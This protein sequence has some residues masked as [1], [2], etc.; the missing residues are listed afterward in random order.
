MPRLLISSLTP[1]QRQQLYTIANQYFPGEIRDEMLDAIDKT[2]NIPD[3][4]WRKGNFSDASR[5]TVLQVLQPVLASFP[6]RKDVLG[7]LTGQTVQEEDLTDEEL[8]N[9]L[10]AFQEYGKTPGESSVR[11]LEEKQIM[12]MAAELKGGIPPGYSIAD[13]VLRDISEYSVQN[14]RRGTYDP[15]VVENALINSGMGDSDIAIFNARSLSKGPP[16]I[17]T[18]QVESGQFQ[19]PIPGTF[20]DVSQDVSRIKQSIGARQFGAK[21]TRDI[22]DYLTALPAD[23]ARSREEYLEGERGRGMAAF[24]DY[25]PQALSELNRSGMLFSGQVEDLLTSK[26]VNF[27]GGFEGLQAEEEAMDN[28]FYFDAA[29]RDA[30]RKELG[31]R[32]DYRAGLES[33]RQ[34]VTTERG[35]RFQSRQADYDRQLEEELTTSDLQRQYEL[36]RSRIASR[37]SSEESA[38]RGQTFADLA[39]AGA[40]AAGSTAGS[41]YGKRVSEKGSIG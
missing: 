28:Q 31:G 35:Q 2:G 23:L 36:N 30:I 37:R 6:S 14:L 5:N 10:E 26:A 7:R 39:S 8:Q 25:I 1:D 21:R 9:R 27:Q 29:Y 24:E 19:E 11:Q 34:R 3:E 32:E 33:E 17:Y 13:K 38:R 12:S 20:P 16:V 40:S 22:E 15:A 4:L 18:R 41:Y